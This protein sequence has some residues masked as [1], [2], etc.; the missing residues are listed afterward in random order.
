MRNRYSA[1]PTAA[2]VLAGAVV[3]YV[4]AV[5]QSA[6]LAHLVGGLLLVFGLMSFLL[7]RQSLKGIEVTRAV[8]ATAFDGDDL[9]INY[10]VS[11][12]G[13]GARSFVEVSSHFYGALARSGES[14]AL[15]TEI[16]PGGVTRVASTLRDLRRGDFVLAPPVVMSGDPFGLFAVSREIDESECPSTRVTVFP[17]TF[18][19]ESLAISSD[20]SWTFSGV[21]PTSRA[22]AGGDFLGTREYRFGDSVRT[23]H[24]PLSA[25]M[26]QLIVKEFERTSSTEVTILLDLDARAMWGSD[27]NSTLE[28][29]IRIAAS[30]ADYALGRGN[31]VQLVGHSSRF[32]RFPPGKGA[33]HQ[34]T[35][36]HFLAT[37]QATGTTPF[38]AV[39]SQVAPQL[40][41]GGSAVIVFP[42]QR[43][44]LDRLGPALEVLWAR[45][46]R[47]TAVV[48][49]ADSFT[50]G[51]TT[52]TP[53]M[54]QSVVYLV[55]RGAS[56]YV[57]SCGGDLS[58]QLSVP[59]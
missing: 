16:V 51:E 28:Y 30:V 17:R 52:A 37:L 40:R 2:I 41:E 9:Q 18:H 4:V 57:V 22:G 21:E 3:A 34:Q 8:Q 26:G 6:I 53:A 38:D 58:R 13:T 55:S 42:S 5:L 36:M 45:R 23:I 47:V 1:T 43:L 15:A 10:T 33:Y 50:F 14:R 12:A 54:G 19:I 31:T 49:D 24:W 20:L 11:N 48:L 27:R 59:L 44:R 39:I 7:A 56:V 35:L 32:M 46:I 29:S 25:R